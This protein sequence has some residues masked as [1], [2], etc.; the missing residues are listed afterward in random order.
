MKSTKKSEKVKLL[1]DPLFLII[2]IKQTANLILTPLQPAEEAK[3]NVK[4]DPSGLAEL[5]I[6]ITCFFLCLQ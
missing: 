3:A 5:V 2:I 6:K 4:Y 1:N